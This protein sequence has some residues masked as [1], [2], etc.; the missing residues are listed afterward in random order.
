MSVENTSLVLVP[1]PIDLTKDADYLFRAAREIVIS[2]DESYD[3]ADELLKRV[4]GG[5]TRL[6][7]LLKPNIGRLHGAHK[8]ACQ[9]F[10]EEDA[11]WEEIETALK[12]SLLTHHNKREVERLALQAKLQD[13]AD[14]AE[15]IEAEAEGDTERAEAVLNGGGTTAISL[16]NAA[17]RGGARF[18][19]NWRCE[20]TNLRLLVEAW[21]EGK[22]P[23]NVICADMEVLN[24]AS[25]A[26]K[27]GLNWPGVRSVKATSVSAG[28]R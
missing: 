4:K 1:I 23:D 11:P 18:P 21:L 19:S 26:L 3:F 22:V 17:R 13:E 5:R 12:Q 24:A 27:G 6:A 10:N 7:E 28:R 9:Q 20:V 2:D 14:L 25:R 15:A 8:A 16:P